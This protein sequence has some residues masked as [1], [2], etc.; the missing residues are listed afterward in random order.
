M[1]LG[2]H[3]PTKSSIWLE[4]GLN[5]EF[6]NLGRIGPFDVGEWSAP[7]LTCAF[8]DLVFRGDG[9]DCRRSSAGADLP[10]FRQLPQT[11]FEAGAETL[12]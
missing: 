7:D 2:C 6:S 1:F 10:C 4:V 9:G 3:A 11:N 8:V 12:P 5:R